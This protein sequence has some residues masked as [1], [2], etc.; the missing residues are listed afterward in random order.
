MHRT[1]I[2]LEEEQYNNLR[3]YAQNKKLSISAIIRDLLDKHVP[4]LQFENMKDSPLHQLKG[5]VSGKGEF[6]GREHN[7]EL[8]KHEGRWN[9]EQS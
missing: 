4:D 3:H 7:K 1:Q 6:R 2:S 8:Y 9:D 5:I